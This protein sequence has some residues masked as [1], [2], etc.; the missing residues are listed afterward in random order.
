[1]EI[2]STY[3]KF[4]DKEFNCGFAHD[5]TERKQA[6]EKLKER[7]EQYR[8]VIE[9]TDT[10]YVVLDEQGRVIDANHNYIRLTGHTSL[11]DILDRQVTEWT[12]PYDVE[13]NQQEVNKCF[14][15]GFVKNLEID[16]QHADGTIV[17]VEINAHVVKTQ[18][19][20]IIVT[21]CR[22]ITKRKQT[23]EVLRE[24]EEKFRRIFETSRDFLFLTM[25]DG[26]IVNANQSAGNM[27][28]YSLEE[29]K[30][31]NI[32]DLYY[33]I[34]DRDKLI[35]KLLEFGFVENVE[36]MGRKKDGTV[37]ETL[38]TAALVKDKNGKNLG[39]QGSIK[40]ISE[41]KRTETALRESEERFRMIFEQG[42]FGLTIADAQFRFLTVNPAFCKMIGYT[43]AELS[44]LTFAD[45]T[46]GYRFEIDRL[47]VEAMARN[48]KNQYITE[49][50]YLKKDGSMF[51]GSL[52]STP[53]HDNEGNVI[54]Y[55]S[56]I[57]D[58]TEKKEIADALI[59][60]Q[61]EIRRHNLRLQCLLSISQFKA[62]NIQDLLD[63]AMNEAI[64][65]TESKL[66]YIF[67]YNET[68]KQLTH[69]AWSTK[70]MKECAI[71]NPQIVY[72]LDK[73]GCWGEVIRERKPYINNNYGND[74]EHEKGTPQGHVKMYKLLALPIIID[75]K[76][77]ATIG[78]ANKQLDYD[79]TDAQQLVILMDS[80]WKMVE[81]QRYQE[82][83]I[84]S[85]EKAEESDKLKSAFLAN[86]SHEIRT[87]M[88]AILGFS[89][90][91]TQPDQTEEKK[92]RFSNLIKDRAFDLLR[93]IEDILDISKIEIGQ[94]ILHESQTNITNLLQ[95]LYAYY[96]L[97]MENLKVEGHFMFSLNI[98][99]QFKDLSIQ[100]DEQRLKQILMNFLDNSFKFTY[101]G[102]IELGCTLDHE[103][104]LFS[105]SDTGIGIPIDK[106]EIIFDRFRQADEAVISRKYGGTGLGLS[107]AKG[108]SDLMGGKI[109]LNSAVN[110]GT[111]FYFSVPCKKQ[112]SLIELEPIET[113]DQMNFPWDHKTILIVEDDIGS[114][115]LLSEMLSTK[116]TSV[117]CAFTGKEA[118]KLFNN[119]PNID[120]VLLDIRLPDESGMNVA[121]EMKKMHPEIPIIAQT[122]YTSSADK[123]ECLNAG[124]N[125]FITKPIQF[126]KLLEL[127]VQYFGYA[128]KSNDTA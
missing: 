107:I 85:K 118:I 26:K 39:L 44:E 45:I 124:C 29:L 50:Q 97:R 109:W 40:D 24:S 102:Q 37:I 104:M 90:L 55:I 68:T 33:N 116:N 52:V 67:L 48:E 17:P 42:Q 10:G 53:V 4:E 61:E 127:L 19:G 15:T 47:N 11:L 87:P 108:L 83:L 30:H 123:I 112:V 41:R 110:V 63:Y 64:E 16:Y 75:G 56:M 74:R 66:G 9:T 91:I 119:N 35:N 22:D 84:I 100:I 62:Q 13:R 121:R 34:D 43:P 65:L 14:E 59:E 96:Q 120:L 51:W 25:M 7:D 73:T 77:V 113:I 99:P 46:P 18:T 3:I 32:Q 2:S 12:A 94:M 125:D 38:V 76:I 49:K 57:Q 1:V 31:M 54:C 8:I 89:E 103:S 72:D 78:V 98:D 115:E 80:V 95:E 70:V 36:I 101:D 111:T 79:Q 114:S 71:E 105:V 88:N 28:G 58:I 106:Q 82:E 128:E 6:E 126:N 23:E 92:A 117:I 81:K 93:I 21:L 5:I 27:S 86:M 69:V 60:S 122:A 20:I